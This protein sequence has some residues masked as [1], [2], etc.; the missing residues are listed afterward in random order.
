MS[1]NEKSQKYTAKSGLRWVSCICHTNCIS[2][3][4][5]S[6]LTEELTVPFSDSGLTVCITITHSSNLPQYISKGPK[7]SARAK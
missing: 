3:K 5:V 4:A 1:A 2:I 7:E 6:I